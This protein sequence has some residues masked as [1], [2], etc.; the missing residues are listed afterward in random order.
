MSLS[1]LQA[2]EPTYPLK[3]FPLDL[4]GPTAGLW[5]LCDMGDGQTWRKGFAFPLVGLWWW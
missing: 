2:S 3:D 1:L 4:E 5:Q